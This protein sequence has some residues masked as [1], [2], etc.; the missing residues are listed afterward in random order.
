MISGRGQTKMCGKGLMES[1]IK[2][3][4]GLQCQDGCFLRCEKSKNGDN[5]F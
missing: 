2:G 1:K 3:Y 5:I 4:F